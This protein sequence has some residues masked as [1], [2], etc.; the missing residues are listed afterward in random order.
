MSD[1]SQFVSS[2]SLELLLKS[3]QITVV[4][5]FYPY[6]CLCP[7]YLYLTCVTFVIYLA[8]LY[9][10]STHLVPNVNTTTA[11]IYDSRD[12]GRYKVDEYLES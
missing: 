3:V 6:L 9:T 11:V 1:E 4:G 12:I 8:S 5:S 7:T 2:L 10:F